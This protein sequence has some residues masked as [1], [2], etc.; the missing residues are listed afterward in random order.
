[1]KLEID[2]SVK[3]KARV[4]HNLFMLNLAL[5]HL[6]MTPATIALDVGMF[7][8]LLPL[9][10][11]LSVMSYTWSRSRDR[12]NHEHWFV[13]V[14]WKLAVSRY[15]LLLISYLVTAGLLL[16]G[17]LLA[18]SASDPNMQEIMRTVFIR[19]S[20]MPVLLMV[21]INFY[22][23]SSAINLATNGEITDAIANRF[24]ESENENAK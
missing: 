11:S 10:L 15:R 6:F 14:H 13:Y 2:E 4:P 23:E 5:F 12:N 22:L 24:P 1:M 17:G 9:F 3:S 16:I 20:I 21:M 8:M 18:M 19:I 7:G